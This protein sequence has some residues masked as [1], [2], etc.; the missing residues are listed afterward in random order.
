MVATRQVLPLTLYMRRGCHLCEDMQQQIGELL[1]PGSF[2]LDAIDID[3]DAQLR[4]QY[5]EWVP[6]LK[7]G[8]HEICHHFL[9]LE[10]LRS[11]Q[12]GYNT[13]IDN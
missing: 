13:T 6:V 10:A 4:A 2:S 11:V 1:E 5:N 7:T 3:A 8:E 12:A 9:D